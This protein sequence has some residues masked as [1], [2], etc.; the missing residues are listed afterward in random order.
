MHRRIRGME[1]RN[2]KRRTEA[3]E[4][5]NAREVGDPRLGWAAR[6]KI[7]AD[8]SG[9]QGNPE[10]KSPSED[11]IPP[12]GV[13]RPARSAIARDSD[14]FEPP[15]G[16]LCIAPEG[17]ASSAFRRKGSPPAIAPRRFSD[18]DYSRGA[19]AAS[20]HGGLAVMPMM[21]AHHDSRPGDDEP[22]GEARHT[23]HC[24]SW[25]ALRPQRFEG[26]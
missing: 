13:L 4:W 5:S 7:C 10:V 23:P 16:R 25:I 15:V 6:D 18:R 12:W 9:S 1:T 8:I 19:T 24:G 11:P 14:T 22:H 2:L 20:K 3:C 26:S 21:A 17:V